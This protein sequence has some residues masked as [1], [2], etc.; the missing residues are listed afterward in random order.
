[1]FS[2]LKKSIQVQMEK[3]QMTLRSSSHPWYCSQLTSENF[4]QS[5][6]IYRTAYFLSFSKQWTPLLFQESRVFCIVWPRIPVS[7]K[8]IRSRIVEG[9]G[10]RWWLSSGSHSFLFMVYGFP[11]PWIGSVRPYFLRDRPIAPWS[12]DSTGFE[13]SVVPLLLV[14]F[15]SYNREGVYVPVIRYF[16]P[17][18]LYWREHL[19]L[20]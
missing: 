7:V 8:E 6:W 19:S 20:W 3:M 5:V 9:M 14:H 15:T 18:S 13:R 16:F 2:P 11:G 1:M 17:S 10:E 4:F 12:K